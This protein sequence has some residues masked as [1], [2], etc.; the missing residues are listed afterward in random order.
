MSCG[1]KATS[2]NVYETSIKTF[3]HNETYNRSS[4]RV[5]NGATFN[6]AVFKVMLE[7]IPAE[8]DYTPQY[9]PFKGVVEVQ[10]DVDSIPLTSDMFEQGKRERGLGM[11]MQQC[12][13]TSNSAR[14]SSKTLIPVK[15]N[16]KYIVSGINTSVN[17][18]W[19]YV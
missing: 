7:K 15:P 16:S 4:I 13:L 14:I 19:G 10:Q 3:Y 12:P 9:E 6:N 2:S 17:H 18:I 1:V 11:S 8:G 5:D